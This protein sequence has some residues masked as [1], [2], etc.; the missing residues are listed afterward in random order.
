MKKIR[1]EL[2]CGLTMN[3]CHSAAT[4][5][6]PM[7]S[8]LEPFRCLIIGVGGCGC[9]VINKM[10][11]AEYGRD[12]KYGEVTYLAVDSDSGTLTACR[13][14]QKI[15][16]PKAALLDGAEPELKDQLAAISCVDMVFVVSGMGGATGTEI[17][18][19]I[20]DY[21][22]QHEALTIGVATLPL[23]T[24]GAQRTAAAET[25]LS[26]FRQSANSVIVVPLAAPE[27]C[28]LSASVVE[29][30]YHDADVAVSTSIVSIVDTVIRHGLIGMDFADVRTVLD[31]GGLTRIGYG[32]ATGKDRATKAAMEAI[33]GPALTKDKLGEAQG[34][35]IAITGDDNISLD[36]VT[37]VAT[38][39]TDCCKEDA[40]VFFQ[41]YY[42]GKDGEL[43]VFVLACAEGT[44]DTRHEFPQRSFVDWEESVFPI[45]YDELESPAFIRR[46]SSFG[47]L[48][49]GPVPPL[50]AEQSNGKSEYAPQDGRSVSDKNE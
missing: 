32:A 49:S 27:T 30:V 13:A 12:A 31:E 11:I 10:I 36:E 3:A 9:A 17:S 42:D 23:P 1:Q 34:V 35:I 45:D 6:A 43:S 25:G 19:I 22:K 20:A 5:K 14:E 4:L 16:V 48:V 2:I 21:A 8:D 39:V 18:P 37:E 29:G 33:N 46:A 38:A 7:N 26:A 28:T 44:R 47:E 40:S 15:S 50:P 24:E 41:G